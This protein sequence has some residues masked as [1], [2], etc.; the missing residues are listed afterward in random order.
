MIRKLTK[1]IFS[2]HFLSLLLV[3]MIIPA[4]ATGG[5]TMEIEA[6]HLLDIAALFNTTPAAVYADAG[7]PEAASAAESY[8]TAAC[9]GQP[10]E[11]SDV[12]VPV[13]NEEL[14][15]NAALHLIRFREEC[16]PASCFEFDV[17]MP[18]TALV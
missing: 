5:I 8:E 7:I 2:K 11:S 17:K 10:A 12:S 16:A 4:M 18:E 14:S 6:T 1:K 13:H 9:A 3:K 15:E